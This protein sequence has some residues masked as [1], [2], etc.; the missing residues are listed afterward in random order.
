MD[1]LLAP[2]SLDRQPR[3]ASPTASSPG[4]ASSMTGMVDT[5]PSPTTSAS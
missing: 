2:A 4:S 5:S 1:P 3:P